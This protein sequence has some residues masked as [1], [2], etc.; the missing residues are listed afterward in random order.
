MVVDSEDVFEGE[1][2]KVE[3][4]A[5]VVVG[6]DGLRVAVDHDGLVAVVAER[7]G[8]MAAA[9][10]KLDSLPDAVR[11]GTKDDDLGL[12]R[13]GRLVLFVVGRV[14]VRCHGLELGGAGIDE[15]E[16]G[17]DALLFAQF[18]DPLDAVVAFQLP[19]RRDA[20]VA[21]AMRLSLRSCS[22]EIAS[23][24]TVL[25]GLLRQRDFAN[26]MQ[27]PGVHAGEARDFAHAHAAFECETDVAEALR[28]RRDEPLG[29]ATR[30]EDFGAGFLAGLESTPGFHERFFEGAADGHDFADGLHLRAEGVV[31]AGEL[32]KLPLWDLDDDV[33]DGGLEAGG[34]LAVMSLGISSSV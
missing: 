3:A 5:G 10:V 8:R 7:E 26:L 6:G 25:E 22:V 4:V 18:P 27:E 2:L 17:A 31:C 32:L 9:I 15:L 16:D 19:L 1:R 13:R 11:S 21:E 23:G 28:F 33:V 34:R 24:E 14:E 12:V 30:L 20:L 29:Q